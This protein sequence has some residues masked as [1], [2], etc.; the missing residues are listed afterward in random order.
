AESSKLRKMLHWQ[1]R[2]DDLEY[3]IRTAWEWEK[4][5]G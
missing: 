5:Q 2:H 3:I 4:K 1:P